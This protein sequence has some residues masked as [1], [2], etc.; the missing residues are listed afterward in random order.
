VDSANIEEVSQNMG[1]L[2][3]SE[4]EQLAGHA[5]TAEKRDTWN[6]EV[7]AR[8]GGAPRTG[9]SVFQRRRR[10]SGFATR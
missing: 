8:S 10:T 4:E 9:T 6:L 7:P 5:N 2:L 1:C 3:A